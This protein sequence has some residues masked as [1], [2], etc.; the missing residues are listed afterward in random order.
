[1]SVDFKSFR[2]FGQGVLAFIGENRGWHFVLASQVREVDDENVVLRVGGDTTIVPRSS[3][4]FFWSDFGPMRRFFGPVDMRMPSPSTMATYPATSI[5]FHHEFVSQQMITGSM[6]VLIDREMLLPDGRTDA[7]GSARVWS[8]SRY[9][10]FDNENDA[11]IAVA[12]MDQQLELTEFMDMAKRHASVNY[13]HANCVKRSRDETM[14]DI[15]SRMSEFGIVASG[16]GVGKSHAL[17]MYQI[18]RLSKNSMYGKRG[19]KIRESKPK[20]QPFQPQHRIAS[21]TSEQR[22][23]KSIPRSRRK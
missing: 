10:Y 9:V 17:A 15:S 14:K 13:T 11:I 19:N 1:M 2:E 12:T 5:V 16:I 3:V 7:P 23:G 4:I 8:I 21:V 22:R 18:A 6:H 20:A